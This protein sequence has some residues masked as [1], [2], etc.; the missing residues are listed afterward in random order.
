MSEEELKELRI[1]FSQSLPILEA[2]SSKIRQNILMELLT[3]YPNGL[4][5]GDIK[6]KKCIT[7]PTMSFHMKLLCKAGLVCYDRKG[8]KNYYYVSID[9]LKLE[10]LEALLA[11][12]KAFDGGLHHASN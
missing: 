6:L 4:R 11:S 10:E 7:R 8:T 1:Y 9:S 12:L 2:L 3:V 5:I